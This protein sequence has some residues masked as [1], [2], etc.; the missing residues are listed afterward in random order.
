MQN[1][2]TLIHD[3]WNKLAKSGKISESGLYLKMMAFQLRNTNVTFTAYG[4]VTLDWGFLQNVRV[5]V[6]FSIIR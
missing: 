6:Y 3:F 4:L 1:T 2:A 5:T